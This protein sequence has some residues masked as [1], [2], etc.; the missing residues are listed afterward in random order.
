M[1]AQFDAVRE[2]ENAFRVLAARWTLALPAAI[3]SLLIAGIIFFVIG[4][5][6]VSAIAAAVMGSGSGAIAVIE[7]GATSAALG[8]GA[9][10]VASMIAHAMVMAAA[11]D[12]WD[13]R[14]P[15]F[16]AA[17]RL[18]LDRFPALLVISFLIALLYAV[19]VVLSLLLIGI[20]LLFVLGYFLMYARAAVVVGGEDPL[21]AIATSFRLSTTHAGPSFIAFLGIIAAFIIGRIVDAATIHVPGIGLLTAFF[22]GGATAAYIALI[23]VRFYTLLRGAGLTASRSSRI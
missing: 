7:A 18:T 23:E 10:A 17:F 3:G 21:T 14:D 12:A 2:L 19:P 20:P 11:R 13:E 22:V 8:I 6:V 4:A 16:S 15:D 9:I 5:V 1:V